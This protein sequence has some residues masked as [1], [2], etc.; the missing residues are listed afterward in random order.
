MEALVS[1]LFVVYRNPCTK[2]AYRVCACVCVCVCALLYYSPCIILDIG[3][4]FWTDFSVITGAVDGNSYQNYDM[5]QGSL[6][7]IVVVVVVVVAMLL[8]R[9]SA[10]AYL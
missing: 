9:V 3:G 6:W 8:I 2:M 4:P 10:D 7:L 1:T 5:I